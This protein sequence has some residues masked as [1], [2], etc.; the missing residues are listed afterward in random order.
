MNIRN[1]IK[2]FFSEKRLLN[3]A[4]DSS[5]GK[6][7]AQAPKPELD[8]QQKLE[9]T[10][11]KLRGESVKLRQKDN[12]SAQLKKDPTAEAVNKFLENIT[13]DKFAKI[14][15]TEIDLE[16][17]GKIILK[18]A[19]EL[20]QNQ[21]DKVIEYAAKNPMDMKEFMS[22]LSTKE[23][24]GRISISQISERARSLLIGTLKAKPAELK[25]LF[26]KLL[27]ASVSADVTITT[28]EKNFK[29]DKGVMDSLIKTVL[30]KKDLAKK[31]SLNSL[32]TLLNSTGFSEKRIFDAL[33]SKQKSGLLFTQLKPELK[34]NIYDKLVTG[35]LAKL[36]NVSLENLVLF[37]YANPA[38]LKDFVSELNKT[39]DVIGKIGLA[40][41]IKLIVETFGVK[42]QENLQKNLLANISDANKIAIYKIKSID[43]KIRNAI[44]KNLSAA[45]IKT[46]PVAK[47]PDEMKKENLEKSKKES[48]EYL[49]KYKT[50]EQKIA[51]APGL[52]IVG[53]DIVFNIAG[54]KRSFKKGPT[55]LKEL[56]NPKYDS[57]LKVKLAC[58]E[59]LRAIIIKDKSYAKGAKYNWHKIASNKQYGTS[60]AELDASIAKFSATIAK[61]DAGEQSPDTRTMAGK[62][63]PTPTAT[64]A[65]TT[66]GKAS[67]AASASGAAPAA[68]PGKTPAKTAK[69]AAAKGP[70]K[71]VQQKEHETI[72]AT[73]KKQGIKIVLPAG[74]EL[75][76]LK[77]TEAVGGLKLAISD[78]Q[79][80]IMEGKNLGKLSKTLKEQGQKIKNYFENVLKLKGVK[81]EI[82]INVTKKIKGK[83]TKFSKTI[84]WDQ[85]NPENGGFGKVGADWLLG[86]KGETVYAKTPM[87]GKKKAKPAGKATPAPTTKPKHRETGH[88]TAT[89]TP[90]KPT[91]SATTTTT[92]TP[93]T[94]AT[95]PA[96][97]AKPAAKPAAA[98]AKGKEYSTEAELYKEMSKGLKRVVDGIKSKIESKYP[99]VCKKLELKKSPTY[100]G[101]GGYQLFIN[102]IDTKLLV[103]VAALKSKDKF[104]PYITIRKSFSTGGD[105]FKTPA[106]TEK[107]L[108][109]FTSGLLEVG[110]RSYD[111][112]EKSTNDLRDQLQRT[113]DDT[114]QSF[115]KALNAKL[116]IDVT[117]KITLKK[118]PSK[119]TKGTKYQIMVDGK[120]S[121]YTVYI[122]T[123]K[124][125]YRKGFVSSHFSIDQKTL[126][127]ATASH[128]RNTFVKALKSVANTRPLTTAAQDKAVKDLEANGLTFPKGIA[129]PKLTVEK[130]KILSDIAYR[131]K[132]S[133][134]YGSNVYSIA[135]DIKYFGKRLQKL[136]F[137]KTVKLNIEVTINGK[138]ESI[139][140][141]SKG[142]LGGFNLDQ[143]RINSIKEA[144]FKGKSDKLRN[145]ERQN[146]MALAT[147]EYGNSRTADLNKDMGN[148]EK[149]LSTRYFKID[150]SVADLN[151]SDMQ[152][153][154]S[155]L[156]GYKEVNSILQSPPFG[157][158]GRKCAKVGMRIIAGEGI[159]NL[160]KWTDVEDVFKY[161][162][163]FNGG[164]SIPTN[165]VGKGTMDSYSNFKSQ[166]A[167]AKKH[168]PELYKVLVDRVLKPCLMLLRA[169]TRLKYT[170]KIK[171]EKRWNYA[172]ARGEYVG[173]DPVKLATRTYPKGQRHIVKGLQSLLGYKEHKKGGWKKFIAWMSDGKSD[174]YL[175]DMDGNA[176][177]IS[178]GMLQKHFNPK[179][180]L[181]MLLEKKGLYTLNEKGEKS[182]NEKALL[183]EINKMLKNGYLQ[184]ALRGIKGRK[185]TKE[186]V[187][188]KL[189]AIEAG[190]GKYQISSLSDLSK[191]GGKHKFAFQLGFI[192][193]QVEKIEADKESAL[194]AT[195][196]EAF[197]AQGVDPGQM[198]PVERTLLK[199]L[200]KR[201]RGLKK[202]LLPKVFTAIHNSFGT[203]G[204]ML[205]SKGQFAGAGVGKQ[206]DLGDGYSLLLGGGVSGKPPYMA[207]Q[208]GIN[209]NI[210][211]N[212]GH[213]LGFNTSIGLTGIHAGLG[214]SHDVGKGVDFKWLVGASFNWWA[215]LGAGLAAGGGAGVELDFSRALLN[216]EKKKGL[217]K[218]SGK[219]GWTVE[220]IK[221]WKKFSPK[222]KM[223]ILQSHPQWEVLK[224]LMGK[225]PKH[226]KTGSVIKMYDRY[227]SELNVDS[228]HEA[229]SG[230]SNFP[231]IPTG[232]SIGAAGI[233]AGITAGP[234]GAALAVIG[235]MKFRLGTV[236]MFIPDPGTAEKILKKASAARVDS[237]VA[238]QLRALAGKLKDGTYLPEEFI[239]TTGKAIRRPGY[240]VG[241][242][243]GKTQIANLSGLARFAEGTSMKEHNAALKPAE[244]R[245]VKQSDGTF[246]LKILN[247]HNKDG[248]ANKDL[249][250]HIDPM[251]KK[252]GAVVKDGRIFLAGN[253]DDLVITR[254]R[255]M[256]A[257][258][259]GKG[260]SSVRDIITIRQRES[261]SGK[262]K[263]NREWIE[264]HAGSF[265]EILLGSE[266]LRI[267]QGANRGAK[268][269]FK[270][271]SEA[272]AFLK[273]LK[274]HNPD[275]FTGAG[276][277]KLWTKEQLKGVEAHIKRMHKALGTLTD[278]EWKGM[279]LRPKFYE[280]MRELYN[281]KDFFKKFR[282]ITDNPEKIYK[283]LQEFTANGT[284]KPKLNTR[285]F[286]MAENYLRNMWF[287][288][289]YRSY[290]DLRRLRISKEGKA[291]GLTLTITRKLSKAGLYNM[292]ALD[293]VSADEI[294][295]KSK[296]KISRK[297]ADIVVKAMQDFKN[298]PLSKT[299]LKWKN[300]M[301]LK[302]LLKFKRWTEKKYIADFDAKIKKIWKSGPKPN[303]KKLVTK[304]MDGMYGG[305]IKALKNTKEPIV[306]F[307]K[308][309]L[310]G[311]PQG[312]T[313]VSG[314]RTEKGRGRK[315]YR[316]FTNTMSYE[317]TAKDA[318]QIHGYGFLEGTSKQYSL[319]DKNPE[320][321]QIARILL[322]IAHP[323][324]ETREDVF[325]SAQAIQ[326][327]GL[328]SY[329]LIAGKKNYDTMIGL[330][331]RPVPLDQI[332]LT[333]E[334]EKAMDQFMQLL[335]D[336]R[337]SQHEG[338][339]YVHPT[340]IKGLEI[341]IDMTSGTVIK[342]GAFS[343]CTNASFMVDMNGK[344][345]IRQKRKTRGVVGAATSTVQKLNSTTGIATVSFR[346]FGG[347]IKE[348]DRKPTT[349]DG[350]NADDGTS[351][352]SE[353][354]TEGKDSAAGTSEQTNT[355]GGG[356]TTTTA[357]PKPTASKNYDYKPA[358]QSAKQAQREE[359]KD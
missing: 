191:L 241:L 6:A 203:A 218:V 295:A 167:N 201:G 265:A 101:E 86:N 310:V 200:Y 91:G 137:P 346:L 227:M 307:R 74:T 328:G 259:T 153:V 113:A 285:E 89:A 217:E 343:K 85:G 115:D 71:S 254:E 47:S 225:Y 268:T 125:A 253:I 262:V 302:N 281:N 21:I 272:A 1:I 333:S 24:K 162:N 186:E 94:A 206:I 42:G 349:N 52:S 108:R 163:K 29:T 82:T 46:L 146:G 61:L 155:H 199:T 119:D 264:K 150:K 62:V 54:I 12:T 242:R 270:K 245:L 287:V 88:G 276:K 301:V 246:E 294:V 73:L 357:T 175:S 161:M 297:E 323:M 184:K 159:G 3:M 229:T 48:A 231:F 55:F 239:E 315:E 251:L 11:Q 131:A 141:D 105:T 337:K 30:E 59:R 331:N 212:G 345:K 193:M 10:K 53:R 140:W 182:I 166:L 303:A 216:R 273:E 192:N 39:S 44:R 78:I 77:P 127:H 312:S 114:T 280:N 190:L 224:G 147:Q 117:Q 211:K 350:K 342:S 172:N 133:V 180:A 324:P 4:L 35:G 151:E 20:S 51:S 81:V 258:Q 83:E 43:I 185:P 103:A 87:G 109:E 36:N 169:M 80:A 228:L 234:I 13:P 316:A 341:S 102:G 347:A 248:K 238:K 327:L 152:R 222:K 17:D 284:I 223:Q 138:K 142:K 205:D 124:N 41:C 34:I 240:G 351:E 355:P 210:Y 23:E 181:F 177:K 219:S 40:G 176:K 121:E 250:I 305:L 249:E 178:E 118:T 120:E 326:L 314:S 208:V 356:S 110:H 50:A 291:S 187:K 197:R 283:L 330:V 221:N 134:T 66:T 128:V 339:A 32:A 122:A 7:P 149:A 58:Y 90:V 15:Q 298:R 123:I 352:R 204:F 358:F 230:W 288:T 64:T 215:L 336:I 318:V 289:A 157:V 22:H 154:W 317:S 170:N 257:A 145:Y 100:K 354:T 266:K 60:N 57:A 282:E 275:R 111:T 168:A 255:F 33:D 84:V 322:E 135:K 278:K 72:L 18:P 340:L 233:A 213:S 263:A 97:T 28:I 132:N 214:G 158:P 14:M 334:Q 267:R 37:A 96:A 5:A 325:K 329:R 274:K 279:T 335:K 183:A 79:R 98:P 296:G 252:L 25:T 320:N 136:G 75:P 144:Q 292:T 45:I 308:I 244:V 236:V 99:G 31:L 179:A 293:K 220:N 195:I 198:S 139:T 38:Q 148:L 93:T 19:G 277:D 188:A 348:F 226:F 9:A 76:L 174:I 104:T 16:V 56:T 106:E 247:L 196:D 165:I 290:G 344:A 156:D 49:K 68:T 2:S 67:P 202:K 26:D 286:T 171:E 65:T 209:I 243:F 256:F 69:K 309:K 260:K 8:T 164:F 189:K 92:A 332:L 70:K 173:K 300:K 126:T 194:D 269:N 313:L 359:S 271:A 207:A 232:I 235:G 129:V 299:Q 237:E 63:T 116:G 130:Y 143:K 304:F 107:K 311:I 112:K 27:S 338:K 160:N 321:R 306:D 95:K 319:T 261:L 353:T